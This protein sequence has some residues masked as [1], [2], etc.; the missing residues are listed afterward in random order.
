M[1]L[2]FP[3]QIRHHCAKIEIEPLGVCVPNTTDLVNY[4]IALHGYSSMSSSGVQITGQ[5]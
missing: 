5:T 3:V 2:F 4:R 1:L